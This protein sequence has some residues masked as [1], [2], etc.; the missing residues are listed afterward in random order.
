[1]NAAGCRHSPDPEHHA[2]C[3]WRQNNA[4]AELLAGACTRLDIPLLTVSSHRVFDGTL[5][6]PYTESDP[7][8]SRCLSGLSMAESEARVQA[9]C[10]HA[11]IV[12]SGVLFGPRHRGNFV[13]QVLATLQTGRPFMVSDEAHVSVS[14][15]PDLV[16]RAL[17]LLI[18]GEVGIWHLPNEGATSWSQFARR[19]AASAGLPVRLVKTQREP[20]TST[21]L[22]S[23][24]GPVL[25]PI[26]DA[27][28]R[29]FHAR[30]AA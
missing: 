3:C 15:L 1:V 18:D 2:H 22:A 30:F 4:A 29:F 21:E 14:Y 24:R 10:P 13:D 25:P 20:A 7:P 16:H 26:S 19:A 9:S 27:L 8:T 6:R 28:A 23:S 17:D 11:L 5:G 12:R